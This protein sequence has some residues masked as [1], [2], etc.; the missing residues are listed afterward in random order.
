MS[1]EQVVWNVIQLEVGRRALLH[2]GLLHRQKNFSTA[3]KM[4][5]FEIQYYSPW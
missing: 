3:I 2:Y 5:F 4:L 1:I